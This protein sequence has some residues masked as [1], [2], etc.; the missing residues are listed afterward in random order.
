MQ[1]EKMPIMDC[2][3]NPVFRF[4]ISVFIL[5]LP[6]LSAQ[7]S[8]TLEGWPDSWSTQWVT[9]VDGDDAIQP[10]MVSEG[11]LIIRGK[12]YGYIRTREVYHHYQLEFEWR[13]VR[14]TGNSGVLMHMN[15]P[16]QVWPLCIEVQLRAGNAG[17]IVMINT[18]SGV[19]VRG[20]SYLVNGDARFASA[21]KTLPEIEKPAGEW[22]H[23]KI[24][25]G[26]T[27]LEVW[28]NGEKV[29]SAS[30]MTLSSGFVGFQSEGTPL[31]IRNLSLVPLQP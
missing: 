6:V 30:S 21:A 15:G 28:V 29:N 25:N 24:V 20:E 7:A 10:F 23:C 31:A 26:G 16:D 5:S 2:M 14:E 27:T 4:L 18:G 9:H 22:N 8:K 3:K 19:T 11:T 17:D 13:W 1:R 12:P